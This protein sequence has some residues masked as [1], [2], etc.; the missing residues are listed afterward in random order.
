M[1]TLIRQVRSRYS[2]GAIFSLW[3]AVR[4]RSV[5]ER[6]AADVA[7][8]WEDAAREIFDHLTG[9][10]KP[11]PLKAGSLEPAAAVVEDAAFASEPISTARKPRR[12]ARSAVIAHA[13]AGSATNAVEAQPAAKSRRKA[14]LAP[15]PGVIR[16]RSE[17]EAESPST[18][19]ARPS[20]VRGSDAEEHVGAG[21]SLSTFPLLRKR[22]GES[23]S[24]GLGALAGDMS[25]RAAALEQ[26]TSTPVQ[27]WAPG[28]EPRSRMPFGVDALFDPL[29]PAERIIPG[30]ENDSSSSRSRPTGSPAA[31]RTEAPVS[32]R[33]ELEAEADP[34]CEPP[35]RALPGWVERGSEDLLREMVRAAARDLSRSEASIREWKRTQ[36]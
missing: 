14:P 36:F 5:P 28:L 29:E 27:R 8:R 1:A 13:E 35:R 2:P 20:V 31:L 25:R 17:L 11:V 3:G 6:F 33:P 34:T 7:N 24:V 4:S 19:K 12:R 26:P 18:A 30:L 16:A 32:V 15:L 23:G 21:P 22:R 10:A 9:L